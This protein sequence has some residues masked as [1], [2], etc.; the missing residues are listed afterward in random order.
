MVQELLICPFVSDF[1]DKSN[2]HEL[3]N[4]RVEFDI[5]QFGIQS[6]VFNGS[7]Y[8]TTAPDDTY[9]EDGSK[10][11]NSYT[12]DQLPNADDFLLGATNYIGEYKSGF[13][14]TI[15]PDNDFTIDAWIYMQLGA[16]RYYPICSSYGF[17]FSGQ[18]LKIGWSLQV[19]TATGHL[20]MIGYRGGDSTLCRLESSLQVPFNTWT[21]IVVTALPVVHGENTEAQAIFIN[22]HPDNDHSLYYNNLM[23]FGNGYF[24]TSNTSTHQYGA[25]YIGLGPKSQFTNPGQNWILDL[26]PLSS[27]YFKGK[28]YNLRICRG[29]RYNIPDE[30]PVT[31]QAFTPYGSFPSTTTTTQSTTTATT[32][33]PVTWT[34]TTSSSSS[35]TVST[36]GTT[37]TYTT[38]TTWTTTTISYSTTTSIPPYTRV[39]IGGQATASNYYPGFIPSKAF[40]FDSSTYWLCNP[41]DSYHWIA[42]SWDDTDYIVDQYSIS[43]S[44][45][46]NP[47]SWVFQGSNDGV[48][49]VTLDTRTG[50]SDTGLLSYT[51]ENSTG[52]S[53][54]RLYITEVWSQ[55]YGVKINELVLYTNSTNNRLESSMHWIGYDLLTSTKIQRYCIYTA[56]H[57]GFTEWKLQGSSDGVF[58]VDI[59]YQDQPE[60]VGW[61]CIEIEENELSFSKWRL[62]IMNWNSNSSPGLIE[63]ELFKRP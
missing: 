12:L 57:L 22:G 28:I 29:Q 18:G 39:S 62:L 5:D 48:H 42:Y 21:H 35:S 14:E 38:T 47:K 50:I 54:Y 53:R 17:G 44:K 13:F 27:Y 2:R 25:L 8:L 16:S 30:Y 45:S 51:F 3:I 55:L 46:G 41:Y 63:L 23:R 52:Y 34:S 26:N 6:A 37:G 31:L 4:T 36:T 7:A 33:V 9:L 58:W 32:T 1:S 11:L 60:W 61:K 49:W 19:D 59:D 56:D 43:V 10:G 15:Y 24:P 20:Q 40:D